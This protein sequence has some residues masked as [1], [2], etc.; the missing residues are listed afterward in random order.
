VF[1][2]D[3]ISVF[4]TQAQISLQIGMAL[5]ALFCAWSIVSTRRTMNWLARLGPRSWPLYETSV[6]MANKNGWIWFYRIDCA[7]IFAGIVLTL[8]SH[9]LAR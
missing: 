8:A 9:W 3:V 2:R 7:V 1:S 4:S 5:V 6:A